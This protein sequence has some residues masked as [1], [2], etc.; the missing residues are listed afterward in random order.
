V[1]RDDDEGEDAMGCDDMESDE[2]V[3]TSEEGHV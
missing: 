3:C 2:V 1:C